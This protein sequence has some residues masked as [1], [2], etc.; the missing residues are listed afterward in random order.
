MDALVGE[1]GKYN[2]RSHRDAP[3]LAARPTG[4]SPLG[5]NVASSPHLFCDSANAALRSRVEP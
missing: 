4:R 5:V 1:A 3:L 2:E